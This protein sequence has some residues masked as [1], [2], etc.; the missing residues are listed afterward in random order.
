ML[1]FETPRY[2]AGVGLLLAGDGTGKFNK[3]SLN[4]SGF[5]ARKDCKDVKLLKGYNSD[6]CIVTNNN[7]VVQLYDFGKIFKGEELVL[8]ED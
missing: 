3:I 2:D 6:K 4:E 7:D 8:K 5:F 1:K